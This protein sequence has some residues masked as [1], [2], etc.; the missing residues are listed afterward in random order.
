MWNFTHQGRDS[1]L[2]HQEVEREGKILLASSWLKPGTLLDILEDNLPLPTKKYQ[3]QD[4]NNA[5]PTLRN[6]IY[7]I[8]SINYGTCK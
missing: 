1:L 6:L 3:T 5:M 4:N 7:I 2:Q 8:S